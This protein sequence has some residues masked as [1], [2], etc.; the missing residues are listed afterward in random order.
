MYF[1]S[2][3]TKTDRAIFSHLGMMFLCS[4]A[5][6][7]WSYVFANE[8]WLIL[9]YRLLAKMR[10]RHMA[11]RIKKWIE[12]WSRFLGLAQDGKQAA[13]EMLQK[14]YTEEEQHARLLGVHAQRMR[15]PQFQEMLLRIAA[16]EKKHVEWIGE[17]ITRL[18]ARI[19][20]IPPIPLD[21]ANSWQVLL[22]DLER[23]RR[24]A[25]EL[26]EQ[27]QTIQSEYPELT[28]GLRQIYDDSKRHQAVIQDMLIRSDPHAVAG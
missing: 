3:P 18:G 6:V 23:E 20:E 26:M 15:Y 5:V 16:D 13:I 21:G 25:R 19:P 22:L 24:C 1:I 10:G 11:G 2:E 12:S 14:R 4:K 17:K 9:C 27:M 7:F 8:Q 28:D